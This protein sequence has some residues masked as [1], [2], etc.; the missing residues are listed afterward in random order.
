ALALFPAFSN[1]YWLMPAGVIT[2]ERLDPIVSPNAVS[3]HVH[4]VFGGSN[5]GSNVTTEKLQQS[6]CTST[7]VNEDFSNYWAPKLY[8][9]WKNGSFSDV[10]GNGVIYYFFSDTPGATKPFPDNFRMISG[11]PTKRSFDPND[12]GQK[13]V[14]YNCIQSN[15]Q[16]NSDSTD[17][18]AKECSFSL[19][20]QLFFPNCW[21]GKNL[22]S[23]NH[24]SH[25]AFPKIETTSMPPNSGQKCEDPNFPVVLPQVL[26]EI[27]WEVSPW[28]AHKT[29]AMNPD[30]PFVYAYGDP[31][32]FGNHGDF[33]N[34]WKE[35]VLQKAVDGCNCNKDGDPSCCVQK[36]IFTTTD[37]A[38]KHCTI[39]KSTDEQVKGM[40]PK[41]P[42]S[43]L[44]VGRG[45]TV[46]PAP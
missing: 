42:G 30:Q 19:R 35:G 37:P 14:L 15:G 43:N 25:V 4:T 32:G 18:P 31:T 6:T 22:D 27:W 45:G 28:Y 26:L 33:Y 34:G 46:S 8:F 41:L 20:S 23:T 44:V 38:T 7:A 1:A 2:E 5:F 40:L 12:A 24:K 21:D 9:Q 29:E 11:D 17:L 16:P 39:P 10:S 13:A 3:G 36:G